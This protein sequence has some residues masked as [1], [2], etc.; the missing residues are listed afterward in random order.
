M[1][2]SRVKSLK[3]FWVAPKTEINLPMKRLVLLDGN[4]LLHR[5]YHALPPLTTASGQP[6]GAI[7]GFI[8][9]LIKLKTDFHP[10]GFAVAFDRPEPTFRKELFA[11][12]QMQRPVLDDALAIQIQMV[13]DV[14]EAFGIPIFEMSGYEADD[15][16]G[17][18]VKK[19]ENRKK[20]KDHTGSIDQ[21]I[22]VTGDRDILQLV[23]D[24]NVLV[25][26]PVKGL[27]E[28]KLYGEKEVRERLGVSPSRIADWKA[29]CGDNSDNY[30]GVS[31]IGPK[32]AADLINTYESIETLYEVLDKADISLRVKEKLIAGKENAFLSKNLAT[33][34][35]D[36]PIEFEENRLMVSS[37][38]TP[39]VRAIL[40]ELGFPS[41]LKRITGKEGSQEQKEKSKKKK[42]N[43]D[44]MGLFSL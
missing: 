3:S 6:G 26:M 39:A 16:I 35:T 38:D 36:A 12:Y 15:V 22:I 33:I 43:A 5:A 18:I 37:F 30:P 44:Q 10:M 8:S 9:M 31:G 14:M 42:V 21:I 7:Y 41:L 34:R 29:L 32:T 13:H 24:E 19:I 27:S 40:G 4:A 17:T 2:Q 28:G 20:K 25:Y 23:E 11:K 1:K